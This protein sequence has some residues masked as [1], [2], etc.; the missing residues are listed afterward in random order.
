MQRHA[1]HDEYLR[2]AKDFKDFR[3]RRHSLQHASPD[4]V[5]EELEKS[6]HARIYGREGGGI[7]IEDRYD[8]GTSEEH[9]FPSEQHAQAI[10]HLHRLV[11]D[12]FIG[13]EE[14]SKGESTNE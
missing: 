8:D 14:P 9:H 7:V 6:G 2:N 1:K 11:A 3:A 10:D 12:D 5:Q 4:E 13:K